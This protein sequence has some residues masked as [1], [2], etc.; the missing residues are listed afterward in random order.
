MSP[1]EL[2]PLA[3][4]PKLAHVDLVRCVNLKG[5]PILAGTMTSAGSLD[6]LGRLAR[7]TYLNLSGCARLAGSLDGLA[8]MSDLGHLDLS[9]CR[10]LTGSLAPICGATRLVH[11]NLYDCQG[12]T[13]ESRV[14]DKVAHGRY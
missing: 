3:N 7:V 13:C 5:E 12:L 10:Q 8:T 11:L 9:Y 2:R 1:G 14:I 6:A 4:I